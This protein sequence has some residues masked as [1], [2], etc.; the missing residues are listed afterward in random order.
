MAAALEALPQSLLKAPVGIAVSGGSDSLALLKLMQDWARPRGAV[1]LAMTVDHGLRPEAAAEA[2]QV[3]ALCRAAGTDHVTLRLSG[4]APRQSLLRRRR[5]AA[6]AGTLRDRS[7]HLL[8]TGHTA[9]DQAET[10]L[11]RARQGSGW[12]GLA[13]MRTLSL[14][15]VWPEGAG[16]FVA[17][18]LLGLRRAALQAWLTARGDIWTDDPSNEN[19]AF[20]R[21]RVRRLLRDN[22]ALAGRILGLVQGFAAL[23]RIE[24]RAI[25]AWMQRDVSAAPNGLVVSDLAGLTPE[26]AARSL[27]LLIQITAGRESPPRG[28]SLTRLAK[29]IVT[30]GKF[31]GA[32]LGGVKISPRPDGLLLQ[33]EER[34]PRVNDT[35]A[36]NWRLAA[37]CAVLS[38]T[39]SEIDAVAGK[40]SFLGDLMP[41]F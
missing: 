13:G 5:H 10:F 37:L 15:P 40:E 19:M 30:E 41:I 27:S 32:T 8:L 28:E 1:L 20:E 11:M 26:R 34:A 22:P 9:D 39:A 3:A 35:A 12:Y 17:R 21:V 18:P 6:M 23:R 4:A 29:N 16:V 36:R 33:P 7:G 2:E 25:S 14:S 31:R 24:D 38:G